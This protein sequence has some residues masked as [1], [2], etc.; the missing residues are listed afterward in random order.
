MGAQFQKVAD[1][2]GIQ[3]RP[4]TMQELV[5]H[6][7]D[8]ASV[9]AG[10]PITVV[11]RSQRAPDEMRRVG[12]T[13]LRGADDGRPDCVRRICHRRAVSSRIR[14]YISGW[15]DLF[16]TGFNRVTRIAVITDE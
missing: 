3:A 9:A 1:I 11:A 10:S 13:R 14:Q 12:R 7:Q 4:S 15:L 16:I 5:Y 6:D 8:R 2:I